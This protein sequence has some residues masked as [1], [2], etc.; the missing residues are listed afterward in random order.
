LARVRS[1]RTGSLAHYQWNGCHYEQQYGTFS[2]KLK[3]ELPYYTAIPLLG[4]YPKKMKSV[5]Q[6]DIC[7]TMF[8]AALFTITEKYRK[9]TCP[10]TNY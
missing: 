10:S 3:A 4:K 5:N 7:P 6:R 2:K 9:P 8:F 1:K